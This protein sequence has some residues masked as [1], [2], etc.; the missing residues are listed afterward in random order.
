[1]T[2]PIDMGNPSDSFTPFLPTTYNIPEEEDRLPSFIE[3]QFA[4]FSNVIN[5]K[6]IGSVVDQS[7]VFNGELWQYI[8]PGVFRNGY[9]VIA[10][11]PS[12]PDTTTLTLTLPSTPAS[13][14]SVQNYPIPN[15]NPEFVITQL[16]GTASKPPSITGAGDGNFFKFNNQGDSRISFTMTDTVIVITTT[17]DYTA[18]SG[19]IFISYLRNGI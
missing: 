12:Y 15:V 2:T 3:E 10:Y 4:N 8:T 1:M 17:G 14:G 19:F 9:T 5:D 16:Y 18:Y 13:A 7:S 11:I 6:K